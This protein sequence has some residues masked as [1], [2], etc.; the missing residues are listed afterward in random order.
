MA[1][2]NDY[3]NGA[4]RLIGQ[5]AAGE[6][7]SPEMSNYGLTAFNQMLDSWSTERLSIFSTQDQTF[8]WPASTVSR[9]LGPTGDF[10]GTRPVQIM[11][12][13]YFKVNNLSYG[14]ALVNEDQYNAIALKT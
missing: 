12:S 1:T 4:L 10:V 7:P 14:I 6:T 13:T 9:T 11:D 3:I 2:A 5:L 8:T